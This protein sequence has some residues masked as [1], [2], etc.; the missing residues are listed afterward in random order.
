MQPIV[1]RAIPVLLVGDVEAA[2]NHYTEVLGFTV[3]FFNRE[4]HY[5][6][7]QRD[8]VEI[9]LGKGQSTYAEHQGAGVYFMVQ[10]LDALLTQLHATATYAGAKVVDYGYGQREIYLVDPWGNRFAFAEPTQG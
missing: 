3:T 6:G 2:I 4:Y 7:V 10:N 5:A 8:G 1:Q 9:H